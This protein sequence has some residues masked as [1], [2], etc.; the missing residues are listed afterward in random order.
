MSHHVDV[1]GYVVYKSQLSVATDA[2][3]EEDGLPADNVVEQSL[4]SQ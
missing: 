4:S 2:D 3:I 1:E